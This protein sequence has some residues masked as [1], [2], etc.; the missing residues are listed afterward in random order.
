MASQVFWDNEQK[1]IIRQIYADSA[2]LN[3]YEFIINHTNELLDSVPYDV[4]IITEF[5]LTQLNLNG[6][7]SAVALAVQSRRKNVGHIILVKNS[8]V[9]QTL[10]NVVKRIFP[11][12]SP[13]GYVNTVE[14][15]R[16]L[17]ST[18]NEE[19]ILNKVL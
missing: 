5:N 17:I 14:E 12:I 2:T 16:Q 11:A 18:F 7:L 3:T 10:G 15:A 4:H 9:I 6:A 19:S 1:T 8:P 13:S